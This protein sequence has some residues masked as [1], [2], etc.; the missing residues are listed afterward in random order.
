MRPNPA[1]NPDAPSACLLPPQE[2]PRVHS[3]VYLAGA[4]VTLVRYAQE[5]L[6]RNT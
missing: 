5:L 4:P 2:S 3:V 6:I 1:F